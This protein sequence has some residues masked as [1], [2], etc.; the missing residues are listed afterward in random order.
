MRINSAAPRAHLTYA[1]SFYRRV[2]EAGRSLPSIRP[3]TFLET[4]TKPSYQARDISAVSWKAPPRLVSD[5]LINIFFQEW[6]PLFPVL[7]RPA[8]LTLYDEFVNSS[9]PLSDRKAL[10]QLNL[11][12]G[13]ASLANDVSQYHSLSLRAAH[14]ST[15]S[16]PTSRSSSHS[17]S[18]G[19]LRWSLSLTRHHL[20]LFNA[21]CWLKYSAFRRLI[22]IAC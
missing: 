16:H 22:S 17:N 5:Q 19:R 7:H 6:A 1:D 14:V 8:F 20:L 13:I 21:L 9:E 11:V 18:N 12:F 3:E 4:N 2:Q 10:A 15:C